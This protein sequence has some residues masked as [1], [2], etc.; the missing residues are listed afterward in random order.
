MN[1]PRHRPA[2]LLM[3]WSGHRV[4][5]D[6]GG[7]ATPG[8]AAR[9]LARRDAP[10][11]RCRTS[12]STRALSTSTLG[13]LPGL[14]AASRSGR[15]QPSAPLTPRTATT[16]NYPG[17]RSFVL[18]S[19]STSLTGRAG[20]D[21]MF[22]NA[23]RWQRPI[24]FAGAVGAE[25]ACVPAVADAARRYGVRGGARPHRSTVIRAPVMPA[26]RR[27]TADGSAD[28]IPRAR[29]AADQPGKESTPCADILAQAEIGIDF[30]ADAGSAK[31]I[32]T[33]NRP[34]R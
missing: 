17:H 1:P 5:F 9:R 20:V 6:G 30:V 15:C 21:L 23:A 29:R 24:S 3:K 13:W 12:R 11:N 33:I 28:Q 7:E 27:R 22:A 25:P 16:S 31:G 34:L 19:A 32:L 14:A 10:P 4:M 8:R 2:G 18:L 26:R